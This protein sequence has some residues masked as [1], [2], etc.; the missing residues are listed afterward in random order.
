MSLHSALKEVAQ[1]KA[2]AP[3]RFSVPRNVWL[4]STTLLVVLAIWWGVTALNLI[5]PLFLPA[6]QQVLHQLITIASPQ[7]FMDASRCF[8]CE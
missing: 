1:P 5:S 3:R 4:S 8:F 6:P 7:G 2:A